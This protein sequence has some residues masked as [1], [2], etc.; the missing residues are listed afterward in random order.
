[1]KNSYCYVLRQRKKNAYCSRGK[2]RVYSAK[3]YF[4]TF[5][6]L[7]YAHEINEINLNILSHIYRFLI[8]FV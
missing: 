8:K 1:M 5:F 3:K 7:F 4:T 6:A 2:E